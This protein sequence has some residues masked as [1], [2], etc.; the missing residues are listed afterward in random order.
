MDFSDGKAGRIISPKDMPGRTTKEGYTYFRKKIEPKN[1]DHLLTKT[2]ANA[3]KEQ[4]WY[5]K[6]VSRD[7]AQRI[8]NLHSVDG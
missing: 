4:L 3:H 8:L 7:L 5:H 6:G 1:V 2:Q